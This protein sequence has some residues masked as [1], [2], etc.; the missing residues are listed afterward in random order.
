VR[1][2][3]LDRDGLDRPGRHL[4]HCNPHAYGALVH[5]LNMQSL[6]GSSGAAVSLY[7]GLVRTEMVLLNAQYFD[8]S[9]SESPEFIGRAVAH[10]AAA[11]PSWTSPARYSS[12]RR[13][14][15]NMASPTSMAANRSR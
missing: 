6:A 3:T 10:L 7:P 11:R 1:D 2:V 9:N 13:S 4:G 15:L 8:M 14:G 5:V 12:Q